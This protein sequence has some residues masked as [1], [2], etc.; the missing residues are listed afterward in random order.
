M[1]GSTISYLWRTPRAMQG[2][3]SGVSLHS[4]TN[5]STETLSHLA[6]VG[7]KLPWMRSLMAQMEHRAREN[8]GMSV[9]Y[10]ASYWTPPMPPKLAFDLESKQIE[11]LDLASMVSLTDHDNIKGP[12]LL[13]AVPSARQIPI[14]VEW[15]AP[16][17]EQSLHI[18]VHNLPSATATGWMA[19]LA[20]YT[21]HPNPNRLTEILA[22]LD[23]EPDVLLVFNHPIWDLYMIGREKHEFQA[24]E[25]LQTNGR[26]LHALELNGLRSWDENRAARRLAEQW[27]ML[28]ISG[29][30]RHGVEPNANINITNAESF[31][32]FVHEVRR[33]KKSSLLFMPQYAEPWKYRILQSAIDAVRHYPEFP[34]GSRTWD[35]RVFHP[36]RS[37]QAR[38][39]SQLWPDGNP[40]WVMA[41]S[42]AFVELMGRGFVSGG[43]R[44]VWNESHQLNLALGERD[45]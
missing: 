12:M 2:F 19:I 29:G 20:E 32:E 8:H 10:A 35:E 1:A 15:T 17:G 41:R 14:S 40:P 22:A 4:H 38:P 25:F 24:N 9:D 37:G 21:A 23:A 30:D 33:E 36:D 5:Q 42:I 7:R 26:F 11:K 3:R 34:P 39:L 18:G 45:G 6:V 13:Q 28:L 31:A 43:L 44:M 27:D 16:D